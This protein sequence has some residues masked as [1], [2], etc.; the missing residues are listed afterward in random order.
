MKRYGVMKQWT[1]GFAA[2]IAGIEGWTEAVKKGAHY[3]NG[4]EA[5]YA[6]RP[7]KNRKLDEYLV[8]IGSEPQAK[9]RLAAKDTP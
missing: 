2:G 3:I 9:I 4:W 6:M 1:L 7:E 8:G 5:G